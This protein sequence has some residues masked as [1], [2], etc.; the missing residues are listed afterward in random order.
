MRNACEAKQRTTVSFQGSNLVLFTNQYLFKKTSSLWLWK[1][2]KHSLTSIVK[3]FTACRSDLDIFWNVLCDDNSE[4]SCWNFHN[5]SFMIFPLIEIGGY[6]GINTDSWLDPNS[7]PY[8]VLTHFR[9]HP[10]LTLPT[11]GT[12]H[13]PLPLP[14]ATTTNP[15]TGCTT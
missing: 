6:F 9:Q 3:M 8:P 4:L 13:P 2:Y 11:A 5:G 1:N 15:P 7:I 12:T 14:I 10:P